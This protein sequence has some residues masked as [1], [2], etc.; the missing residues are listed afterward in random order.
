MNCHRDFKRSDHVDA[1]GFGARVTE[2]WLTIQPTARKEWPPTY[3]PLPEDY[4]FE[5]F[6]CGGPNGV[7]LVVLCLSWW[8]NALT[9][10]MDHTNFGLVVHD[11]HWTLQQ[12]ASRA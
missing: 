5:Y 2:W 8:A 4:S 7:F 3:K 6:E 1:E 11:V 10:G 12:I 9:P